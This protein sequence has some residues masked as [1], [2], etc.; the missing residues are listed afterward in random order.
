M[1]KLRKQHH[2][3]AIMFSPVTVVLMAALV[4]FMVRATVRISGKYQTTRERENE[5][6][7]LL[8]ELRSQKASLAEKI[9]SLETEDGVEAAL[10]QHFRIKKPGEELVVILDEEE[11]Q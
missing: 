11:S 4:F 5:Q 9:D 2:R 10:R 1:K 6:T 7:A 3:Q 8:A